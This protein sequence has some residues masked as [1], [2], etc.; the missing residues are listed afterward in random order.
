MKSKG[1]G[2]TISKVT[3][4]IGIKKVVDLLFDDCGCDV[5]KEKLNKLFPYNV[6]CLSEDDFNYLK[7][8]CDNNIYRLTFEQRQKTLEIYNK[9]FNKRQ[10]Q[11]SCKSC[12]VSIIRELKQIYNEHK[13]I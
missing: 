5:R 3:K 13:Q 8:L 6:E 12:W 4:A 2:D 10:E 9:T 11:T 7:P 1:L